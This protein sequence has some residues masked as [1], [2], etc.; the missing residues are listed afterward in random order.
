MKKIKIDDN[1]GNLEY[2]KRASDLPRLIFR[3][4]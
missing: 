3:E 1:S 2:I 4:D